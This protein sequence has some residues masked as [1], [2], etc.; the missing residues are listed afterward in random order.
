MVW[1]F[2]IA[3]AVC[4]APGC[5]GKAVV[6]VDDSAL[7]D[8]EPVG[9]GDRLP[10]E[11]SANRRAPEIEWRANSEPSQDQREA[12]Q[13]AMV[14]GDAALYSGHYEA[15]RVNFLQAMALRPTS[16]SPALGALRS[17]VTP[18]NREA[19]EEIA[20]RIRKKIDGY[21]ARRETRGAAHLLSARLALAM[22]HVGDGLDE[23]RM[24]V[25]HM[26]DL[27]V[28]WRILGE[29]AMAAELWGEAIEALQ[30]AVALG[31][32][33]EAGSWERLAD[34]FDE[35]GELDAAE[36]AA[37]QA[38][39]TTGTDPHARRR[40]LNLL[41]TILKHR[42]A[43]EEAFDVAEDA[44][45][46]GPNDPAVLHNLGSIAEARDRDDDALSYYAKATA[47]VPVPTTLWRKGK[48]LLKLDRPNEALEAFTKAYAH[49]QRW[50][51]P[52]STR[53]WPA[54]EVGKLYARA[55]H[56]ERAAG[57]FED[58]LRDATTGPATREIVSWLGFVKV[59]QIDTAKAP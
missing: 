14:L 28:A 41:A 34:A 13:R 36:E 59:Q 30:T 54:Y 48:L 24:A 6:E 4:A 7:H 17:M 27:G 38:L 39:A 20:G 1:R 56:F 3:V 15:A 25:Q 8:A 52:K 57:W 53:W 23:A 35:L 22:G 45:L 10:H 46:L 47:E 18:G 43:L 2:L 44:R 33:A 51:W 19:R 50:S 55:K 26:P 40:R 29:A 11:V 16:M 49:V 12:Y 58:A 31:L 42:G 5:R 21:A 32:K 37:E 9:E